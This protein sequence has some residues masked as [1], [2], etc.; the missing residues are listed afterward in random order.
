[1]VIYT[2]IA[3]INSSNIVIKLIIFFN[4]LK[5]IIMLQLCG[6]FSASEAIQSLQ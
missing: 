1:M 5:I 6:A 2:L 4:F 3:R